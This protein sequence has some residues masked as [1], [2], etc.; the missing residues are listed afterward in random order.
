[1]CAATK[2]LKQGNSTSLNSAHLGWYGWETQNTD[3]KYE[4]LCT[5]MVLSIR[6]KI[7]MQNIYKAYFVPSQNPFKILHEGDEVFE[8][9]TLHNTRERISTLETP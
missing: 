7:F 1:M 2:L 4:Y 6:C 8:L 3:D 5:V 9:T